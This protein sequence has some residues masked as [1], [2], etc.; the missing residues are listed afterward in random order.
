MSDSNS[1]K[2]EVRLQR[3]KALE[4]KSLG[5][6]LSYIL[7][8]YKFYFLAG[9]IIIFTLTRIITNI[10]NH[11]E[12]A[13]AVVMVNSN[14]AIDY[15]AYMKDYF[16]RAGFNDKQKVSL[17]N[18]YVMLGN[19]TDYQLEQRFFM[20]TATGQVDAII[21]P[22]SFFEPYAKMGYM[23]D[24]SQ[25]LPKEE[26]LRYQDM[27]LEMDVEAGNAITKEISGIEISNMPGVQARQ[28]YKDTEEPVYFGIAIESKNVQNSI[29]FL[30]D[31][32]K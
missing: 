1:L 24:L 27:C 11:K 10:V 16:E 31:I 12:N 28:W 26:L 14:N 2:E 4:G 21:A 13:L 9:I 25:V 7:Y 20:A 8:Y 15:E 18:S 29:D 30:A 19:K 32:E 5:A 6:K 17:D 3:K 23:L 22:A